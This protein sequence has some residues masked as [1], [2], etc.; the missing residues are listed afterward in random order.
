VRF[1]ILVAVFVG[2]ALMCSL[3]HVEMYCYFRG[4]YCYHWQCR[5]FELCHYSEDSRVF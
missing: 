2:H 3:P 1:D 4:V 5:S